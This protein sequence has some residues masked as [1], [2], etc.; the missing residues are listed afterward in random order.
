LKEKKNG[1]KFK[2]VAF[3]VLKKK[4]FYPPLFEVQP[5]IKEKNEF[6]SIFFD[7]VI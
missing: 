4:S 1:E 6:F 3:F 5:K 2:P 7:I